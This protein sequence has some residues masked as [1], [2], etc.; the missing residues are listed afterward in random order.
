MYLKILNEWWF[1][2]DKAAE[3]TR[4]H[5]VKIKDDAENAVA[6]PYSSY[7]RRVYKDIKLATAV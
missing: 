7:A 3:D 4:K 6:E 5:M 1:S 2:A